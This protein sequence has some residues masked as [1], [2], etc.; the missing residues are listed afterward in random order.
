MTTRAR[1]LHYPSSG[2]AL[3]VVISAL[4]VVK[5]TSDTIS[6]VPLLGIVASAAL[7]L[8]ETLEVMTLRILKVVY[9]CLLA[10]STRK[11]GAVCSAGQENSQSPRA[12][13]GPHPG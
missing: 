8:T 10:E 13:H 1:I 2:D 3:A 9:S 5:V 12:Y 6:S 11:Q 7:D 4:R